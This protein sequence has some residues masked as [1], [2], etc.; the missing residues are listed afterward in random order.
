MRKRGVLAADAIMSRLRAS[1][2]LLKNAIIFYA[3][4]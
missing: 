2:P 1:M 4:E 3:K